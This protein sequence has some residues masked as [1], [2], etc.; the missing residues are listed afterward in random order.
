EE[1]EDADDD[2]FDE[3]EDEIRQRQDYRKSMA[4]ATFNFDLFDIDD[5]D[6]TVTQVLLYLEHQTVQVISTIQDL[7][8]AIKKPDATR[9]ELRENS[10]AISEVIKQMTEATNTSMNQ[11]RNYLLR[12]H[13]S[14]VV[15]SLEDCN[16]RMNAL[17]KPNTEKQDVEFA[18]RHFKQRLAGIS[19]D[20]AKCTKELVK[21]VE[22]ASLKEDIAH[23]DARLNHPDDL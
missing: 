12:E 10:G 4:A 17:C 14:W 11:T 22:E 15:K 19:F 20:I 3:E 16:H 9:G 2:F 18:D 8:S 21:T 23:L 5:P 6:N 13:G 7:L 1:F